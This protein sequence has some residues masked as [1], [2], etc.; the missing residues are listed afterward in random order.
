MELHHHAL[1]QGGPE[2]AKG[3]ATGLEE[4]F[5]VLSKPI[6]LQTFTLPGR[7]RPEKSPSPTSPFANG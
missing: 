2:G 1:P 5:E 6:L 7:P 3:P 4:E